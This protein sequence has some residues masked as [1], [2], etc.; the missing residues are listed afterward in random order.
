ML[1]P[2]KRHFFLIYQTWHSFVLCAFMFVLPSVHFVLIFDLYLHQYS[3]V[4]I[5]F[6]FNILIYENEL[7]LPKHVCIHVYIPWLKNGFGLGKIT[8]MIHTQFICTPIYFSRSSWGTPSI[9]PL[10]LQKQLSQANHQ[11]CN[12][13]T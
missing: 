11:Y 4:Q 13:R 6:V 2:L 1:K 10:M 5:I 12:T 9:T 7:P 3:H 8:C